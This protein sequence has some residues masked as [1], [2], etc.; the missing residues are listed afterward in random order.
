MMSSTSGFFDGK[1]KDTTPLKKPK[2]KPNESHK[3]KSTNQDSLLSLELDV[4]KDIQSKIH[5][6]GKSGLNFEKEAAYMMD[7]KLAGDA[8]YL[9]QGKDPQAARSSERFASTRIIV[10]ERRHWV[11]HRQGYYMTPYGKVAYVHTDGSVSML[12]HGRENACQCGALHM[13]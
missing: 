11:A 6:L 8:E 4:R 2:K 3:K 5:E 12:I 10:P 9:V 13:A 1:V 7:S